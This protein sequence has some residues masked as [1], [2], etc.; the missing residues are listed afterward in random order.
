[1]DNTQKAIRTTWFSLA[2]NVCLALVKGAAGV[3]GNSYAL[4]A[5][6]IESAA[7]VLSSTLVLVGLR[8]ASRPPDAE[9]PYGHGRAEPLFTFLIVG[10]L[11]GSAVLI[12]D[13]S[14]RNISTP[15]GPPEAWTLLVLA[16]IIV[17]K[18]VS[19][20]I[21]MRRARETASSALR[22]DA[23][24]H[25]SDAV[26]SVAA[27]IGISIAL[28]LGPGYEAADD[29]AALGAAL[30]ILYNC[31]TILRPALGEVMDEQIHPEFVQHI[32]TVSATVDGIRGTEKCYVRKAGTHYFV[33]LHA[34]VD[35]DLSVREGHALAHRLKDTIEH[36][37][38]GSI[39][40]L[41]HI[42]PAD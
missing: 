34:S 36:T 38:P 7:D 15:H 25:R 19:Y 40:V 20:R 30:F 1:M 32:R 2:S 42:E 39:S 14:I 16:P 9:H 17:W 12:G 33:D 10:F 37:M 41:I 27:F 13:Q 26:T 22:A 23:W 11:V 29:W 6:A 5:D 3:F 28:L 4:V 18:E 35:P 31:Y 8:Y 24:H 21:V